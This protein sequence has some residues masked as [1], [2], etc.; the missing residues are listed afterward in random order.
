ML[1]TSATPILSSSSD[2]SA[3]AAAVKAAADP[4]NIWSLVE[5][6]HDDDPEPPLPQLAP[7][8]DMN[9]YLTPEEETAEIHVLNVMDRTPEGRSAY[10]LDLD[11]WRE[12]ANVTKR[13]LK[14]LKELRS[15]IISTVE[16]WITE[17]VSSFE[18]CAALYHH[19]KSQYCPSDRSRQQT[20]RQK[21]A[22]LHG[23]GGSDLERWLDDW[24]VMEGYFVRLRMP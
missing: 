3:W 11:A 14:A 18:T 17:Q 12:E 23:V 20:L 10:R 9:D 22:N 24:I 19:L 6:E 13:C 4:H 8:P 2:W 7:K 15:F 16:L 5:K 21:Y 1:K